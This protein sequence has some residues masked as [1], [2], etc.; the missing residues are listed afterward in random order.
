MKK[1]YVSILLSAI[2]LVQI[3]SLS[4]QAHLPVPEF[5]KSFSTTSNAGHVKLIWMVNDGQSPDD[6]IYFEL[7]RATDPKFETAKTLYKGPDLASFL[8][9]M[10]DGKFYFRVRSLTEGEDQVSDWSETLV[11]N[12][13]HQSLQLAFN[14]FGI[15]AVVFLATVAVVVIGN[16]KAEIKA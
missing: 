1:Y 10:P 14:L 12:V 16:R 13:E 6:H 8:S 9:G 11:I 15:G 4:A 7:Q 5:E 3:S 2:L